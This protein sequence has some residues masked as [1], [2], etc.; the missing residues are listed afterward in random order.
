MTNDLASVLEVADWR[1]EFAEIYA[2]V[3]VMEDPEGGWHYWRRARDEYF[4]CHPATPLNE[5]ERADFTANTYYSYD[6]AW[7]FAVDLQR[8]S[9]RP[10]FSVDLDDDGELTLEPFALT[11]GLAAKLGG[12]LTIYR[13]DG[14][15]G[16]LF[17]P[18]NDATSGETTYGGGRY[19]LD[20]IKGADLG[21]DKDG[22]LILDFN[23]AYYPSCAHS[24]RWSCPLAPPENNLPI[25]ITAGQRDQD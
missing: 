9:D 5:D 13:L 21:Q 25:A 23:F 14:Y 11:S 7:Y 4:R 22:K 24:A 8:V 19:L 18:F 15:G 16:G 17:L 12:E 3:R 1:R 2:I 20:T 10:A 6:P